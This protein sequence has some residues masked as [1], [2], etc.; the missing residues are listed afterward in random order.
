MIF[1][2]FNK[3]F[4]MISELKYRVYG[5]NRINFSR[6]ILEETQRN[7][8]SYSR[9]LQTEVEQKQLLVEADK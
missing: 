3:I 1:T 7:S 9:V 5:V 6:R 2:K 8:H 4:A